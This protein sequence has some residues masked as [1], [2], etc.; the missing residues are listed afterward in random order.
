MFNMLSSAISLTVSFIIPLYKS[1][2]LL[3]DSQN[4]PLPKQIMESLSG[5]VTVP[6][7]KAEALQECVA[8][9]MILSIGYYLSSIRLVA[10]FG[11]LIPFKTLL[12]IY[13]RVWLVFPMVSLS[14]DQNNEMGT[15]VT[16]TFIIYRYYLYYWLQ[17]LTAYV[18]E[19]IVSYTTD[20]NS[21]V[22]KYV[23]PMAFLKI[24]PTQLESLLHS[25]R[26]ANV[27]KTAYPGII[28]SG[29]PSKRSFSQTLSDMLSKST[30]LD[31]SSPN[32]LSPC[33]AIPTTTTQSTQSG[34]YRVSPSSENNTSMRFLVDSFFTP[35]TNLSQYLISHSSPRNDTPG[36]DPNSDED[37]SFASSVSSRHSKRRTVSGSSAII[38][39]GFDMVNDVVVNEK[40]NSETKL[41]PKTDP[42]SP[43]TP[44]SDSRTR[45]KSSSPQRK[46]SWIF[47]F[48]SSS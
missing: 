32:K 26:S 9:W 20:Y 15:K 21:F 30:K 44:K 40:G 47:S 7:K 42:R 5:T 18:N 16:G 14:K 22:D 23:P 1:F 4:D 8:Y 12:L 36:S 24:A 31:T 10:F 43:A 2:S 38:V 34:N 46:S 37:T 28:P 35:V 27:P 39:D 19:S 6:K 25:Q 48:R 3:S 17:Q 11:D 41:R 45:S 13:V 33:A 29:N